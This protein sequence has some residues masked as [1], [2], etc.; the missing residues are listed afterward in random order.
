[1]T[2]IS[3]AGYLVA[4]AILAGSLMGATPGHAE[5]GYSWLMGSDDDKTAAPATQDDGLSIG[6][7]KPAPS[8][9]APEQKQQFTPSPAA[10][11]R[12]TVINDLGLATAAYAQR[13]DLKAPDVDFSAVR[14]R[15]INGKP[16]MVYLVEQ[17]IQQAKETL[18]NKKLSTAERK[19]KGQEFYKNFTTLANGLRQR[20]QIPD[21]IY[22]SMKLSDTYIK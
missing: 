9:A 11:G 7:A 21:A 14:H 17:R 12:N 18:S 5:G 1:M 22:K 20:Q 2:R 3:T 16:T 4:A 13:K 10:A 6:Q 8:P 19:K 15:Q